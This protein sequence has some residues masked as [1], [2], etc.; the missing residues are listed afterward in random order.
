TTLVPAHQLHAEAA[1]AEVAADTDA[2]AA[3]ISID[4][5]GAVTAHVGSR[6][7]DAMQVD[8]ARGAAG[9]GSGRQAGST[10]KPFVLAAALS[11]EM[12]L[13]TPYPAPGT[14]E[15]DLGAGSPWQV[16]NY[17]G[18]DHGVA[19]LEHA[20]AQSINTVYA[21][22]AVDI[23]IEQVTRTARDAGVTTDLG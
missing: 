20:T 21:Q 3:L 8:L 14:A 4:A 19:T 23:G 15:I 18:K 22:L 16:S 2:D 9:G 10:F 7:H 12:P 17:G 5:G 11:P 13:G 1:V 6:D